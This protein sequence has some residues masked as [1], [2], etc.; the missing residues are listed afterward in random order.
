[1]NG[2]ILTWVEDLSQWSEGRSEGNLRLPYWPG[3][4]MSLRRATQCF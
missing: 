2:Q 3:D 4:E 1:M